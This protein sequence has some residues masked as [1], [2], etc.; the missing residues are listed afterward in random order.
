M[1]PIRS[2]FHPP[3]LN[4]SGGATGTRGRVYLITATPQSNVTYSDSTGAVVTGTF[5]GGAAQDGRFGAQAPTN[6]TAAIITGGGAVNIFAGTNATGGA[7][8]AIN[9]GNGTT[10]NSID[11]SSTTGAGGDVD[12][13][14]GVTGAS[15]SGIVLNGGAGNIVTSVTR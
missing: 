5:L 7:A 9:I 11:T 1:R 10:A 3:S 8:N 4:T 13:V 6:Q 12:L 15:G 2:P 14:T